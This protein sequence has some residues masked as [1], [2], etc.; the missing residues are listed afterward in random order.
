MEKVGRL[1]HIQTTLVTG[2]CHRPLVK[3]L[4]YSPLVSQE[5]SRFI[6]ILRLNSICIKCQLLRCKGLVSQSK[7]MIYLN[8]GWHYPRDHSIDVEQ[9]QSSCRFAILLQVQFIAPSEKTKQSLLPCLQIASLQNCN[10]AIKL[11]PVYSTQN[12][13]VVDSGQS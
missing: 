11:N 4:V 10:L 13:S 6:A 3:T 8:F 7:A 9:Q 2:H 1:Y 5:P 12:L